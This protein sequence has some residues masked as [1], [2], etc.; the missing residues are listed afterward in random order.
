MCSC[1]A[2]DVNPIGGISKT[3][4]KRFIHYAQTEFDLP[5]L[6]RSVGCNRYTPSMLMIS[7]LN[8]IPSAELIPIG[9]DNA[10]QSDEIEM[11]MTYDELSVYGR[12]RKVEKCGPF[13]MFGKLVQEWGKL[14]SPTEVGL[15]VFAP[16]LMAHEQI[17]EK[18]KHF[19]FMHAINRHK[20]CVVLSYRV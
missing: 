1:S 4:L 20:M 6:E 12:L 19:F 3:D 2:A 7:F 17:A 9:A 13:S 5:I 14:Y 10:V 8:A 16:L 15:L 11:G 18:V